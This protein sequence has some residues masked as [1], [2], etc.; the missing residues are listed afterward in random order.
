MDVSSICS[1]TKNTRQECSE[2]PSIALNSKREEQCTSTFW[3]GFGILQKYILNIFE[4]TFHG[5]DVDSEFLVYN[6]LK[7]D[8]GSLPVYDAETKVENLMHLLLL[9]TYV[10]HLKPLRRTSERTYLQ[11]YLLCSVKWMFSVLMD[12]A[13]CSNMLQRHMMPTIQM[14]CIVHIQVLIKLPSVT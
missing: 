9:L 11:S 3:F 7:S 10:T 5:Q 2:L 8:K 1:H 6:L 13:N 14:L 4:L 12:M